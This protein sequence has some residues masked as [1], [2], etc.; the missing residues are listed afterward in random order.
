M[1]LDSNH[2]QYLYCKIKLTTH[3]LDIEKIQALKLNLKIQK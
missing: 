1:D 3:S 2:L